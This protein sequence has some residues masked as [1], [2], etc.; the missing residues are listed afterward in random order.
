MLFASQ[1]G[2]VSDRPS[3]RYRFFRYWADVRLGKA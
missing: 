1:L 3:G 2:V